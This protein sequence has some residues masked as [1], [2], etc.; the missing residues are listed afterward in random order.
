MCNTFTCTASDMNNIIYVNKLTAA[1]NLPPFRPCPLL[2]KRGWPA[3]LSG[4]LPCCHSLVPSRK[5]TRIYP[6]GDFQQHSRSI[7]NIHSSA[8]RLKLARTG[9]PTREIIHVIAR[10]IR[11]FYNY[12]LLINTKLNSLRFHWQSEIPA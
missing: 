1:S 9:S 2:G 12:L 5:P 6:S 3:R 10:G 11:I 8:N 4:N 7:F